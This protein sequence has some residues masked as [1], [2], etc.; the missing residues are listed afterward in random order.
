VLRHCLHFLDHHCARVIGRDR[1]RLE[2]LR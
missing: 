1:Q 2:Y